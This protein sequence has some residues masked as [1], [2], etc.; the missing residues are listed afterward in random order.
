ML[1]AGEK[2]VGYTFK[3]SHQNQRRCFGKPVQE[4]I[5][6]MQHYF[7]NAATTFMCEQALA[8]YGE[9][10]RNYPGNPSALHPLGR[11]ANVRLET[12]RK[13]L[14]DL[15]QVASSDLYFTSGG[16]ESN[17]IVLSSLLWSQSPGEIIISSIE[18]ASAG[19]F[20][21]ILKQHGWEITTLLAP[22]GFVQP[23]ALAEALTSR[24]RMVCIQTVN[25]VVGSIQDI[26]SLV[27]V[28]RTAGKNFGRPIHFHTDAVQALG[29]IKLDLKGLDVD[30]ASFSAH[31][32]H[33][34][35]GCGLLYCKKTGLQALSRGGGQEFGLR[36]GTE[37]LSA[38]AAMEAAFLRCLPEFRKD[39]KCPRE[40]FPTVWSANDFLREHLACPILSPWHDYSPFILEIAV[41]PFP[42]EV[43]MRMLSDRGFCVSSGSACSNNARQKGE[44]ILLSMGIK[45]QVARSSIRL[46]FSDETTLDETELLCN[47]INELYT[48]SIRN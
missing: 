8:A 2:V 40:L 39:I 11:E 46:S 36:P 34:P 14:A 37:N 44:G 41:E 18:H 30:S 27:Q 12:I 38:I 17:S 1:W 13:N 20:A 24:T 42:S 25:N 45:P 32:L 35:R 23:Q 7:D 6:N 16:T 28:T 48:I 9:T 5:G 22:G 4:V 10:A 33:G 21:R 19:G 26:K 43:F 47:T 3:L 29:K 31:K 15:L